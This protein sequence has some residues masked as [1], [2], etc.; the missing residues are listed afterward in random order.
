MQFHQKTGMQIYKYCSPISTQT[1]NPNTDASLAPT[2][3]FRSLSFCNV[4]RAHFSWHGVFL[5]LRSVKSL[6][7]RVGLHGHNIPL[8]RWSE[9]TTASITFT[10]K[11]P[12]FV[13]LHL[14]SV[15][16]MRFQQLHFIFLPLHTPIN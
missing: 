3:L 9:R 10:T 16:L 1:G 6:T 14:W 12:P 13:I 7:R 4:D 8:S 5:N 15:G 2:E 11:L